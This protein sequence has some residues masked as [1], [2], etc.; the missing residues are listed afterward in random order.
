M[1]IVLISVVLIILTSYSYAQL[2][3][4][5]RWLDDEIWQPRNQHAT[6]D[7]MPG[8]GGDWPV[9]TD[10]GE[11]IRLTHFDDPR[12]HNPEIAVYGDNV[13]VTWFKLYEEKIY[14]LRSTNGGGVV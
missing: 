3:T 10:W 5:G 11:D 13:Y 6:I 7:N 12:A 4:D 9:V 1:R 2:P 14:F 8:S